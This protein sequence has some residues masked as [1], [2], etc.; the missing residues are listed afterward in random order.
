[1]RSSRPAP[2]RGP[3]PGPGPP[4]QA[5]PG[6]AS[7][8]GALS[9]VDSF[10][11]VGWRVVLEAEGHVEPGQQHA[12]LRAEVE[13]RHRPVAV[14]TDLGTDLEPRRKVVGQ[15][16]RVAGVRAREAGAHAV[17]VLP[18]LVPD[19]DEALPRELEHRV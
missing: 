19:R 4:P 18:P 14:V 8:R 10:R 1:A 16:D 11:W 13:R 9:R 15:P 12:L 7:L 3:A 2:A 5:T 6:R 17:L